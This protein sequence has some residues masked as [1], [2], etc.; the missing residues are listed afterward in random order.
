MYS[1]DFTK[2]VEAIKDIVMGM[3]VDLEKVE[4]NGHGW[5]A[6]AKRLRKDTL[7]ISKLGKEFR[8]MSV[9]EAKKKS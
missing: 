1:E 3:V 5:K 8:R 7:S 2:C 9:I 6:S 4:K